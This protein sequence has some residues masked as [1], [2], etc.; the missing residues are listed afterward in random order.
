MEPLTIRAVMTAAPFTVLAKQSLVVAQELFARHGIRHLPVLADG[1]LVGLLSSRDIGFLEAAPAMAQA[2]TV[3][4]VMTPAPYTVGPSAPLDAVA[5]AMSRR[6]IGSAVV[7][8]RGRVVGVFTTVDALRLLSTLLA[9]DL[10][11]G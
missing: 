9:D 5:G 10:D 4:D 2:M 11:P 8:D 1:A 6:K 7:V 3:E